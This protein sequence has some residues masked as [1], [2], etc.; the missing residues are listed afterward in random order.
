MK[1]SKANNFKTVF[2]EKAKYWH[3][4]KNSC[5]PSDVTPHSRYDAWWLCENKHEFTKKVNQVSRKDSQRIGCSFCSG[6]KIGYGNDF[7]T[8]CK[9]NNKE[10]LLKEWSSK[11]NFRPEEITPHTMKKARWV[12]LKCGHHWEAKVRDRTKGCGC[13]KCAAK[14]RSIGL[15]EKIRLSKFNPNKS[16]AV[17]N[18]TIAKEWH[19]TRNGKLTPDAVSYGS[20]LRA[21][22]KCA[23]GHEWDAVISSRTNL[24]AQCPICNPQSSVIEFRVYTELKK[25]FSEY[26]VIH[27]YRRGG[28]AEIDVFIPSL[29]IGIEIDGGY[30]HAAKL[31]NDE[32]KNKS[33]IEDGVQLFRLRDERLKLLSETDTVFSQEDAD[34]NPAL[35][36]TDMLIQIK[37]YYVDGFDNKTLE[38]INHYISCKVL[39]NDDYFKKHWSRS[40]PYQNLET[41]PPEFMPEWVHAENLDPS[42][43]S[44]GSHYKAKWRCEQCGKIYEKSIK[45]RSRGRACPICYPLK[46]SKIVKT[47]LLKKNG[48]LAERFPDIAAEW[49]PKRNIVTSPSDITPG[50]GEKYWWICGA[51]KYE[52]KISPHSRTHSKGVRGCPKCS[53]I[54]KSLSLRKANLKAGQSL[55]ELSPLVA[56]EWHSTKNSE[57]PQ[58]YSN[59]SNQKVW[60]QCA[61]CGQEWEQKIQV[62]TMRGDRPLCVPCRKEIGKGS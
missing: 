56:A 48:S 38:R 23:K 19:P 22:W 2:P 17:V 6:R 34:N 30:H 26:E 43:F 11:N 39:V 54:K 9:K 41:N 55:P 40:K 50:T 59:Q 46:Q 58:R 47:A 21:W 57:P 62:R 27:R 61:S 10:N 4:T 16:L 8:F 42:F 18:P 15:S 49:H 52:W 12:C 31:L 24:A 51:C 28:S 60:W 53:P 25:V 33:C 14:Y 7:K 44:K 36:V 37:K 13:I 1:A 45:E 29:N 32:A 35:V 5:S 3:P 20:G